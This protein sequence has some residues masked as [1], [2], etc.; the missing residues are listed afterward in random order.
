M[1]KQFTPSRYRPPIGSGNFVAAVKR[2]LRLLDLLR[3][4]DHPNKATLAEALRYDARTIQSDIATLRREFGAPIEFDREQNG[5]YLSD[6]RWRLGDARKG[7][8]KK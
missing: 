4:G 1:P 8:K 2:W 7:A 3:S 6:K 5:F